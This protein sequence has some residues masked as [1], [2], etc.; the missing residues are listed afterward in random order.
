MPARLHHSNPEPQTKRRRITEL[1]KATGR[2]VIVTT[3]A[4]SDLSRQRNTRTHVGLRLGGEGGDVACR[5]MLQLTRYMSFASEKDKQNNPIFIGSVAF[6]GTLLRAVPHHLASASTVD[7][8]SIHAV[9]TLE[10][11]ALST[12]S[13]FKRRLFLQRW[14]P[15][16]EP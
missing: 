5:V 14:S 10:P 9:E 12:H 3:F 7:G 1:A 11:L 8:S 2:K 15:P 13:A 4:E 16:S 6:F